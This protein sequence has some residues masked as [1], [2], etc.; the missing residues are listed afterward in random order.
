MD[1]IY[2]VNEGIVEEEDAKSEII[3]N[4]EEENVA[5]DTDEVTEAEADV[6]NKEAIDYEALIASDVDA[7]K[8]EF[9]DLY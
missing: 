2:D 7:L 1:A 6:D 9:P 4:A 5:I 8:A 3:Q